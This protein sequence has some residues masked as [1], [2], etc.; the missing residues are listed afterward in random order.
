MPDVEA[1]VN[2]LC[3][4]HRFGYRFENGE[5]REI[6]SPALDVEVVGPALLAVQRPGW[7]QV[8]RSFKEAL[9][10]Q[11]GGETDDALTAAQAALEAALKA[12]GMKGQFEAMLKQFRNSPIIPPYLLAMPDALDALLT[13]LDRSNAVRSTEG[14]AHGKAP[15]AAPL[16]QEL[17]ALA[18]HLTG[19]F[20]L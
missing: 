16:P 15:G 6:G 1:Q 10:H 8:E 14:D 17:A 5:A 2:E 4:R 13:L 9:E 3:E 18:I 7:D 20:I 11:R 12:V 19:A